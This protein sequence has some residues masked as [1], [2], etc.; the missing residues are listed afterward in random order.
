VISK[1]IVNFF[2]QQEPTPVLISSFGLKPRPD[3]PM[4]LNDIR[5]KG[6]IHMVGS[7]N[8][9]ASSL[10][11]QSAPGA[12]D[13]FTGKPQDSTAVSDTG[14]AA[15]DSIKPR[16]ARDA[17]AAPPADDSD[18]SSD[19]VKQLK[20]QIAQLQKQLMQQMQTLQS[21]QASDQS[22]DAKTAAVAAA[23]AQVTATTAAL[24][25]ATAALLQALTAQGSSG[26]GSM[27]STS[28]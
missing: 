16:A 5:A 24:Q 19:T 12:A 15:K 3:Q 11:I 4:P 10:N 25:A 20:K 14:A 26:S 7:I 8:N 21:I 13:T 22:A 27:V 9:L 2:G 28:A 18:D 1:L 17:N 23:Q 6:R